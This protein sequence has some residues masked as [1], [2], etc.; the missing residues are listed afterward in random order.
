MS[1]G[2]VTLTL[3]LTCHCTVALVVVWV[4][5]C[6]PWWFEY[7]IAV[8]PLPAHLEVVWGP[9]GGWAYRLGYHPGQDPG[10]SAA[11]VGEVAGPAQPGDDGEAWT[12]EKQSGMC[13]AELDTR[14]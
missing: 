11:G 14:S 5:K 3:P 7:R 2:L 4:M 6:W 1:K 13:K 8:L 9:G 10:L 12:L